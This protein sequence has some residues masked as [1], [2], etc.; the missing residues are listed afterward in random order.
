MA[1]SVNYFG[2]VIHL[3]LINSTVIAR[4]IVTTIVFSILY[5]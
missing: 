1:S 2:V 5:R 3:G 4:K